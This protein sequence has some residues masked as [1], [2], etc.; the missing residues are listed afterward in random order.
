M[1]I[2][3]KI[4]LSNIQPIEVGALISQKQ[5]TA[6]MNAAVESIH[7]PGSRK[8]AFASALSRRLLAQDTVAS[9]QSCIGDYASLDSATWS[10]FSE[11]ADAAWWK[12]SLERRMQVFQNVSRKIALKAFPEDEPAPQ[13]IIQV[14]CTGYESP[15]AIQRLIAARR[16]GQN[17]HALQL[18][19]MGCYAAIPACNLAAMLSK[20]ES[21]KINSVLHIE[22]CTLHLDPSS[23]DA[24]QIVVQYLFADG[25]IRYDLGIEKPSHTH[26]RFELLDTFERLLPE[27]EDAMT[28]KLTGTGFRMTLAQNVPLLVATNL[29][30]I[31]D[32]FLSQNNFRRKDV[33]RWA[34]HPG[35]S[36]IIEGIAACLRLE[37]ESSLAHSRSILRSRGN[38]SSATLPHIWHA[39]L[40]DAN[41]LAGEIVLSLAFGPGLTITG[42]LLRK[43]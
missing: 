32:S 2:N 26:Q 19:H 3:K 40:T 23:T 33:R 7:P 10:L 37:D 27:S 20:T 31:V 5:G 24:D 15:T 42:N 39:M 11:T 12:P 21:G 30:D 6:W 38:M 35:G 28:W 8:A 17:T 14:T 25:A 41:V 13:T 1:E 22:L 29:P 43:E 36:K 18:G 9:R 16:W 4:Y 34:I